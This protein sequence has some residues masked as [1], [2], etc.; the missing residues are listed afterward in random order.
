[1][2][3]ND[4][5]LSD[6]LDNI[7]PPNIQIISVRGEREREGPEIIFEEMARSILNLI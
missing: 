2:K 5:I 3:N 7:K 4:Q 1:M 6:I